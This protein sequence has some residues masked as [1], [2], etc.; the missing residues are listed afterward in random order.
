[1]LDVTIGLIPSSIND[2]LFD[3]RITLIQYSGSPAA[4]FW[5]P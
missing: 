5:T 1:M 4:P 3:A 2:P